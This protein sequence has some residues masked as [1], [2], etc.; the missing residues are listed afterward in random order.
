MPEIFDLRVELPAALAGP[1]A[2]WRFIER[3]AAHL[4]APVGADDGFP[5]AEL[6][7]AELRLGLRLPSAMRELY[8]R[9]GRRHDLLHGLRLLLPPEEL[10]ADGSA[11]IRQAEKFWLYQIAVPIDRIAETDPP[12]L[13]DGSSEAYDD[14]E[15]FA[16]R[17]SAVC[18]ET[19]MSENSLCGDWG[20]WHRERL[21]PDATYLEQSLTPIPPLIVP[22][23]QENANRWYA[24]ADVLVREDRSDR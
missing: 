19:V 5:E 11:L 21:A 7:A 20:G 4:G 22:G 16:D 1:S 6:A 8:G 12:V 23:G 15:P 2:A 13:I 18:V 9:F 14:W 17:F 24:G 3:F 10:E